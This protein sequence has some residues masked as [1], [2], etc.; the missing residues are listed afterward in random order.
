L[1]DSV[2][3][4]GNLCSSSSSSSSSSADSSSTAILRPA[5]LL[6]HS[7]S[8]N[9]RTVTHHRRQQSSSVP[10]MS[11]CQLERQ[12]SLI[13]AAWQQQ[14]QLKQPQTSQQLLQRCGHNELYC[15]HVTSG[16]LQWPTQGFQASC[17]CVPQRASIGL[18]NEAGRQGKL[19]LLFLLACAFQHYYID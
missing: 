8:R 9:S 11:S 3:K 12:F 16:A 17:A 2:C 15:I 14:R 18:H 6:T 10:A 1:H 19:Y 4:L 13:F 7:C 5:A